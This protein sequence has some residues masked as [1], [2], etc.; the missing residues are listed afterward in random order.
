MSLFKSLPTYDW[1]GAA[2]ITPSTTQTYTLGQLQ[3][4]SVKNHGFEA[5]W[6]CRNASLGEVWYGY[7][8]RGNVESGEFVPTV[9]LGK[10]N[11]P[12]SV[13]HLSSSSSI[14]TTIE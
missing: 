1:L 6:N 2:G 13:F 9:A 14:L 10:S 12:E 11:C 5:V 8:T 3:E 4:A 7:F